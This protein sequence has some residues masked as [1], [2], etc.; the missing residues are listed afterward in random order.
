MESKNK[1][2]RESN[3][4]K[5]ANILSI[6]TFGYTLP[7]FRK[8]FSRDLQEEDIPENLSTHA[9]KQLGNRLEEAWNKELRTSKNPSL[10]RAIARV[11]GLKFMALGL[12]SLFLELVIKISQPIALSQLITYYTDTE[13]GISKDK[14]YYY[15]TAI[16][17]AS[18]L[19]VLG[20]HLYMLSI[21]QFAMTVRV[22]TCSLIYRKSLKLN[23]SVLG[24][25]TIGQ[26]V[27]LLSNDVSRFDR[28][29]HHAHN[30]WITPIETIIV[31]FL[32][33]HFVGLTST[34]GVLFMV[35]FVPFQMFLGKKTSFYRFKTALK[36]DERVRLMNEIIQGIQ[37]IKMYT[38]E[39]PFAKLVAIVRRLEI[40]FIRNLSYIKGVVL[41]F[42]I[43]TTSFAIFL[44]ILT[45]VL[46]GN[47]LKAEYV[48]VVVSFYNILR[49][50]M[51]IQLPRGITEVAE[52]RVSIARLDKFLAYEEKQVDRNMLDNHIRINHDNEKNG[53]VH[54]SKSQ[55]KKNIGIRMQNVTAKWA[56]DATE[57]TLSEIK[58]EVQNNDLVAIIGPVGSG[59]TS[60][61]HVLLKELSI[62]FG[63]LDIEGK[64]SYASQEPW[65]FSASIKQ[66]IVFGQPFE[67]ERYQDVIRVCALEHDLYHLP[68]GDETIVGERG[69]LLS[70]GQKARVSL[71]RTIYK[72]ADIYLLDDPLSAVDTHV[73]KQLYEGCI[74]KVLEDKCRILVTHQLQ[75]LHNVD[76]VYLLENGKIS[77][78]GT[79]QELRKSSFTFAKELCDNESCESTIEKQSENKQNGILQ[80]CDKPAEVKEHR[81][82]GR[83]ASDVYMSYFKSGG[84]L[85][86]FF[87]ILML[88][89]ITQGAVNLTDYFLTYWVNMEQ[90]RSEENDADLLNSTNFLY[91]SRETCLYI[92]SIL[93][94]ATLI[95]ALIRSFS[96]SSYCMRASTHL[97][98][99]LFSNIIY[100]PMLFFNTNTSGRILNRFS[101]D[102]GSIDDHVPVVALDLIQSL[103]GILGRTV[104]IALVNPWLLLVTIII[105]I[106][107]CLLRI[108]YMRTSRSLK[109][110]EG[111]TRSP[112]FSHLS[113]SLQ[114]LTTI[115]AFEAEG[116][117]E[118]EFDDHQDLHTCVWYLYVT[119]SRAFAFWLDSICVVYIALVTFSFFLVDESELYGGDVGLAITQA[120]S[121][122]GTFQWAMRQWTE[123]ENQMTSVERVIE[124]TKLEHEPNPQQQIPS[125]FWPEQANINFVSLSLR[126]SP[127]SPYVLKDLNFNIKSREKIGIV[128]RTGAGKSSLIYALFQLTTTDGRMLID[129]ID[130]TKIPLESLRSK[131]SIIPQQ[132]VLFSG[133]LR[134]NLDPFEQYADSDL[135]D[136]LEEVELKKL[137]SDL[138]AGLSSRVSEGGSNFSVGQRQL[139]KLL[140]M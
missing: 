40:R 34:I 91:L 50:T 86:S 70:G 90:A 25:T 41:S 114:G 117:L 88:F 58:F 65:I 108:V 24:G 71:A 35:L 96:F 79:Y 95:L 89:V 134:K 103:L 78:K 98:D 52:T 67:T 129:N 16:V 56:S 118:K 105:T 140:L 81:S 18:F 28:A 45:Y 110:L 113:A 132:P 135:W 83:V 20:G 128:G 101:K 39:K 48:F 5:E 7:T 138:P 82:I 46:L 87:V 33:Y 125:Q 64:I 68:F 22:A 11:F 23:N 30:L 10:W 57:D 42:T 21:Q 26:M 1:I 47:T 97:H 44:T 8:G 80:K 27:N 123:L 133:T 2:V 43:F 36:T 32:L 60:L 9:S 136:A 74:R 104:M 14:A 31:V 94:V 54:I 121:L 99:N 4:K 109:R 77:A 29:I 75:Y 122:T 120:M 85:F 62:K 19:N 100:A 73:G 92:Y 3:P 63:T 116:I 106:I 59:K 66:N 119:C 37:V 127:T 130:I 69:V 61:L 13:N 76:C 139:M 115:R 15:S 126:Y 93:I 112:V 53:T 6:L 12:V 55:V 17:M 107:F 72:K 49:Q 111:I 124:Y 38:W 51:T 102:V 137:V 131:I 84:S